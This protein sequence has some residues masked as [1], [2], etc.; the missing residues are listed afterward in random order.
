MNIYIGHI[1]NY[2][3]ISGNNVLKLSKNI[4]ACC[5]PLPVVVSRYRELPRGLISHPDPNLRDF[6][7][8]WVG[9]LS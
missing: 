6:T 2:L 4:H 9:P 3:D 7:T 1:N 5:F 8:P